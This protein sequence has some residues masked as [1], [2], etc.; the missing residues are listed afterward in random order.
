MN[1]LC[2]RLRLELAGRLCHASS[3]DA[4]VHVEL[5]E[6]KASRG[7]LQCPHPRRQPPWQFSV[8]WHRFLQLHWLR[9]GLASPLRLRLLRQDTMTT[10]MPKA[11]SHTGFPCSRHAVP[12]GLGAFPAVQA[13]T[14]SYHKTNVFCDRTQ[15][16]RKWR[17]LSPT[18]GFHCSRHAVPAG[19][20]AFS[21]V[22][23]LTD[24]YHKTNVF[25][26]R[27]AESSLPHRVS[28]F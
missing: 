9:R 10:Q 16:R 18:P 15:C 17:K 21:A 23:A 25:C 4:A 3:H 26:D 24:S 22:Q 8:F 5:K 19:L 6:A 28:L 1:Q 14:D 13:L 2:R 12:A 11:F 7:W 27:T 20:G